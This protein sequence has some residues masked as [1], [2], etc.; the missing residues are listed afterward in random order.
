MSYT[1]AEPEVALADGA[2]DGALEAAS[3]GAGALAAAALADGDGVA[4]LPHAASSRI[5][6]NPAAMSLWGRCMGALLV[7]D[8]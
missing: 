6:G 3:L 7:S 4:P 8:G 5:S 1:S 2:L